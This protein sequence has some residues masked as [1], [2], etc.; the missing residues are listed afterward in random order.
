MNISAIPSTIQL[1][2][3]AVSSAGSS[4]GISFS[5]LPSEVATSLAQQRNLMLE[6]MRIQNAMQTMSMQSN[7]I[8][9]EHEARMAVI[10]NLRVR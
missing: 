4:L 7:L 3:N 5:G 2:S 1:A 9:S 8:K 10:G 6:Q